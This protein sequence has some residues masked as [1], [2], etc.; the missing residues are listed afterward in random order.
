MARTGKTGDKAPKSC[1][2]CARW[3]EGKDKIRVTELLE[4]TITKMAEKLK[5][6]DF[7]PSIGDYLKLV[8]MEQELRPRRA[9]GDQSDMGGT[10]R[11]PAE[12]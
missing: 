8:Q 9:E 1:R 10:T 12:K 11:N 2:E 4:A 3:K 7:R 6:D 5:S